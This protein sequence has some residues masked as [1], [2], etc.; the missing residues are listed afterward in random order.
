MK[1]QANQY[2]INNF[3]SAVNSLDSALNNVSEKVINALDAVEASYQQLQD[4]LHFHREQALL[5]VKT[6]LQFN[7]IR[8]KTMFTERAFHYVTMD[9]YGVSSCLWRALD[10]SNTT[11]P[12]LDMKQRRLAY[13]P[14]QN[15]LQERIVLIN[16]ADRYV[17]KVYSAYQTGKP[18]LT[19]PQSYKSR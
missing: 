13:L 2:L 6:M 3:T 11:M 14:M 19:Y 7:F 17:S 8:A 1:R 16:R 5:K 9:F 4:R 15:M 18:L 10:V 12:G